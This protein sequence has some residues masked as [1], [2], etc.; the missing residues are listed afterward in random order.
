[1]KMRI[2]KKIQRN[3]RSL[4]CDLKESST[5]IIKIEENQGDLNAKIRDF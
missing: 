3:I 1:M 5:K 4:E 2:R